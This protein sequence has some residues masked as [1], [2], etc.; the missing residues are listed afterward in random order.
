MEPETVSGINESPVLLVLA[1]LT[2][3][4]FVLFAYLALCWL[5]FCAYIDAHDPGYNSRVSKIDGSLVFRSL[6]ILLLI[7]QIVLMTLYMAGAIAGK[8]ILVEIA[9]IELIM[10][11]GVI[12]LT[13]YDQCKFSGLP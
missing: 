10:P 12:F 2:P 1:I 3:E 8:S 6:V 4:I 5:C 9:V 11:L 13:L 7:L